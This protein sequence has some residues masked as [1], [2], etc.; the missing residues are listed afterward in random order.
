MRMNG[1]KRK[2]QFQFTSNRISHFIFVVV[3]WRDFRHSSSLTHKDDRIRVV[4]IHFDALQTA[5]R[6]KKEH[7]KTLSAL[8]L[9]LNGEN[10]NKIDDSLS[11]YCFLIE[12]KTR[13]KILIL[14]A[15]VQ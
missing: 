15:S 6:T 10:K 3:V 1:K 8:D 5:R 14:L 12:N 7:R 9:L 2:C 13:K 4:W 11:F